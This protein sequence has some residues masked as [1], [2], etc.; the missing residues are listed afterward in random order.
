M[1]L[2]SEAASGL[3]VSLIKLMKLFQ[4]SRQHAPRVHPAVDA[5]AYPILF[6]LLGEPRRVSA[7]AECVHSDISTVS[8]QVSHLV[9]H[10]LLEKVADPD[11]RRAQVVTLSEE[12]RS[13][14]EELK[15]I[16]TA[17]LQAM[18]HDWSQEDAEAFQGYIERFTAGLE[19]S[20]TRLRGQTP[21][22]STAS[23]KGE[24]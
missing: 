19:E 8:R 15:V 4:A 6:N 12:G 2:S 5:M 9:G 16:R 21:D 17:W 3:F 20:R 7:L 10:G 23:D 11:D 1:A 18:L 22:S 13:L 24:N 14:L